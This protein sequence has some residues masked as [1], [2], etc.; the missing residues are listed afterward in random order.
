MSKMCRRGRG[1]RGTSP[2]AMSVGRSRRCGN[3]VIESFESL[4]LDGF[5]HDAVKRT[6]HIGIFGRDECE[7]IAGAFGASRAPDAM[8]VGIGGIGHV[9]VDD[10]RDGFHIE[11]TRRNVGGDHDVMRPGF[12]SFERGLTLSLRSISMQAGDLVSGAQNLL[13]HFLCAIFCA[14]EDQYRIRVGSFEQFEQQR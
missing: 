2:F 8:D 13:R 3:G 4:T 10:V 1:A 6:N 14:C 12:E 9:V 7:C 11:A 5:A